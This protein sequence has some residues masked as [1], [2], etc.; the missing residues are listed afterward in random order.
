M[1]RRTGLSSSILS[2]LVVALVP[3]LPARADVT[4]PA[5][6]ESA[7]AAEAPSAADLVRS[8][9]RSGMPARD[10]ADLVAGLDAEERAFLAARVEGA[11]SGGFA[12]LV[13]IVPFLIGA[14]IALGI[15]GTGALVQHASADGDGASE[16]PARTR[17]LKPAKRDAAPTPKAREADAR[18][19]SVQP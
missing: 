1:F 4:P 12:F 5:P 10:A 3:A 11:Q 18:P 7:A 13:P 16:K 17:I 15:I 8:L 2:A 9:V 19:A 14:A 6:L